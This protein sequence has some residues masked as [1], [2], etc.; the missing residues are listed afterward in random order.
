MKTAASILMCVV[1]GA[2]ALVWAQDAE[3]DPP[4]PPPPK[5]TYGAPIQPQILH[6]HLPPARHAATSHNPPRAKRA[7]PSAPQ[8]PSKTNAH[9]P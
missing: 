3:V 8:T 1:L 7:T 4:P 2:P 5:H 6:R 9:A